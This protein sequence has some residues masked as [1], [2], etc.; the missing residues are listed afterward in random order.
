MTDAKVGSARMNCVND[1]SFPR[2]TGGMQYKGL[3]RMHSSRASQLQPSP[4]GIIKIEAAKD[5]G[6]RNRQ[7]A[8]TN[9]KQHLQQMSLVLHLFTLCIISS[10]ESARTCLNYQSWPD[11]WTSYIARFWSGW[12]R[13]VYWD[14]LTQTPD[15]PPYFK[16]NSS[17]LRELCGSWFSNWGGFNHPKPLPGDAPGWK[18]DDGESLIYINRYNLRGLVLNRKLFRDHSPI[19]LRLDVKNI[20]TC[21]LTLPFCWRWSNDVYTERIFGLCLW[22]FTKCKSSVQ[23]LKI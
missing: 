4:K 11:V 8:I 17:D 15:S 22:L 20:C 1:T 9:L 16:T 13:L 21:A 5:R 3:C 6:C 14:F 2:R 19:D 23:N 7:I 12:I 10:I 18:K